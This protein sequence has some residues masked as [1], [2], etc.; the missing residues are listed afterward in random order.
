MHQP[1]TIKSFANG[2]HVILD[3]DIDFE[4]L[5]IAF[6]EKFRDSAKFFGNAKKAISFEGRRLSFL[7]ERALV[8]AI[9]Q[10]SDLDIICVMETDEETDQMYMRAV[11]AF[12]TGRDVNSSSVYK[13]CV[14]AGQIIDVGGS[15]IILGDVNPSGIVRATGSVVVLGTVYGEVTAAKNNDPGMFIAALDFKSPEVFIGDESCHV[16]VKSAG[17]LRPKS[18]ARIVYRDE[19]GI[20]VDELSK[21]FLSNLP[22]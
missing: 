7:E 18:T 5:Y 15:I 14:H 17:F 11:S 21:E 4:Q 1:V 6:A 2:M 10:Y 19:E 9:E 12:D 20:K 8:E 13:G 3:P 16:F 22:F